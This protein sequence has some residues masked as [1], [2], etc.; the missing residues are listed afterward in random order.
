MNRVLRRVFLSCGIC[1]AGTWTHKRKH[2]AGHLTSSWQFAIAPHPYVSGRVSHSPL[3]SVCRVRIHLSSR[4]DDS[5]KNAIRN[6]QSPWSGLSAA[7]ELGGRPVG[8]SVDRSVCQS[9]ARSLG[10]SVCLL[11][12]CAVGP[13]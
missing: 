9:V 6:G 7:S 3:R 5:S 8:R 11:G 13:T 12:C 1:G 2:I 4:G 10:L